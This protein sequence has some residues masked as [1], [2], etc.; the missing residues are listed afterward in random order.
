MVESGRRMQLGTGGECSSSV[1]V[2]DTLLV[3]R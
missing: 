1:G 3:R 2:R